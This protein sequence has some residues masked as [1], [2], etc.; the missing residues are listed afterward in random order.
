MY[1]RKSK[2]NVLAANALMQNFPV[3][4]VLQS[5]RIYFLDTPIRIVLYRLFDIARYRTGFTSVYWI[6][7]KIHL[8]KCIL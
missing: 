2:Q 5:R 6:V 8:Y 7:T 3:Q 1:E 4:Y